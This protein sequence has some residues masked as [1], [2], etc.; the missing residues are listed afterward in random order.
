VP[1]EVVDPDFVRRF[2]DEPAYRDAGLVGI[3]QQAQV[4]EFRQ[5]G[6]LW[7]FS[8][9]PARIGGPPLVVGHDTV[10]LLTELGYDQTTID[11]LLAASVVK[12]ATLTQERAQ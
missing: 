4:G 12:Q 6:H 1:C 9:T 8:D 7:S 2:F 11:S 3:T 5:F 10:A